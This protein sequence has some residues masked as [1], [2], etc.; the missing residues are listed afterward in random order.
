[1]RGSASAFE[2]LNLSR[3]P[4]I[5]SKRAL[6]LRLQIP[7]NLEFRQTPNADDRRPLPQLGQRLQFAPA[8]V[9]ET[10]RAR[11][12]VEATETRPIAGELSHLVIGCAVL[13]HP[14]DDSG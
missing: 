2:P 7:L 9:H 5:Q 4:F 6:T 13:D 1:M 8:A 14:E 11:E 3:R 12:R 10:S